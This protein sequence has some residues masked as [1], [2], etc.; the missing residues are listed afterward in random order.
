MPRKPEQCAGCA[1]VNEREEIVLVEKIHSKVVVEEGVKPF[2]SMGIP[3]GGL[4]TKE[5]PR[6]AAMRETRE[7]I[8]VDPALIA[9]IRKVHRY[10]TYK[11]GIDGNPDLSDPKDIHVF[12][13]VSLQREF[14]PKHPIHPRAIWVPMDRV[15]RYMKNEI[16]REAFDTYAPI[17][18]EISAELRRLME[19]G[20]KNRKIFAMA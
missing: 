3:K 19:T 4:N 14:H 8:C 12:G 9:I 1:I 13:A 10:L 18:S 17:M 16:D 20:K 11:V 7:E 2:S 6:R 15:K 5:R